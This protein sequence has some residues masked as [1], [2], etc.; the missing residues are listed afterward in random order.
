MAVRLSPARLLAVVTTILML[1]SFARVGVLFFEALSVVRTERAEDY[2]LLEIC[3]RGDARGSTKMRE[4]CLKARADLAAPLVF[5][6]IVHAVSTAFKDF[7]DTIGSPFKL[8]VCLLFVVSSIMLP[9]IPWC[10]ALFG[11][12]VN[13]AVPM[14]GIHYIAYTPEPRAHRK[15][16]RT[17]IGGA[18]QRLKIRNGPNIEEIDSDNEMDAERANHTTDN[19]SSIKQSNAWMDVNLMGGMGCTTGPSGRDHFK[20]E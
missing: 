3:Q 7:S 11:Q 17:K 12:Q 6:A 18:L 10:R 9:I 1:Y 5:K 4:A 2:E 13:D 14:D 19:F 20:R 16:M 15:S 8:F